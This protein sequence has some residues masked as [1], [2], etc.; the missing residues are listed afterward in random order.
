MSVIVYSALLLNR[1]GKEIN[2]RNMT[3]V[4]RAA[5]ASFEV[6]DVIKLIDSLQGVDID[7]VLTK[8]FTYHMPLE[9]L[10]E[11]VPDMVF[12]EDEEEEPSG[13]FSL[14]N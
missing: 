11:G 4:L 6:E 12:E 13:I 2:Q 10:E 14:F 7:E 3:D 1:V 9:D 8:G 5:D